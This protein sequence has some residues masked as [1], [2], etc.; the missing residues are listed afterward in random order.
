MKRG[1]SLAGG[2][3]TCLVAGACS[4]TASPT[5]FVAPT[6]AAAPV[7]VPSTPSPGAAPNAEVLVVPTV[8]APSPTPPCID[9]LSYLQDL[10]VPDGSRVAPGQIIDKQWQV[11]NS[12]TCNWDERYRLTLIGGDA[13]GAEPQQ[14]LYPARAGTEGIL[15]ILFTAPATEGIYQCQWQAVNPDGL[16]F[17]DAFYMEIV[18]A[19]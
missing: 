12:G 7:V 6:M 13:M 15:R 14:P 8:V 18:V 11:A 1:R 17:G 16:Q 3:L 19:P 5:V 4:T 9:G 10:T 2:L